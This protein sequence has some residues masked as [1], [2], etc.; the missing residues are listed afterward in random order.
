MF[1]NWLLDHANKRWILRAKEFQLFGE[2]ERTPACV[3]D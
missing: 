1:S 3:G 2:R